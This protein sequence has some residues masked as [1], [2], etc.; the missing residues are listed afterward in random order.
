M[1]LVDLLLVSDLNAQVESTDN[2]ANN[3]FFTRRDPLNPKISSVLASIDET[4]GLKGSLLVR[5]LFIIIK[6]FCAT[7]LFMRGF[8]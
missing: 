3:A 5:N 1:E 2:N 7:W 4:F 8:L 6:L